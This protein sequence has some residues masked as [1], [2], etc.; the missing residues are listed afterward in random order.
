[1]NRRHSTVLGLA[2]AGVLALSA[3]G[4]GDPLDE[5]GGEEATGGGGGEEALVIGSANFPENV[6][7][8]EI[9]AA[10]LGDAGVPVETNLNIGNREA[11]MLGLEDG[12]IDLIPEYTGNLT[13]YLNEAAEETESEA[14]YAELQESLPDNLT[15]LDM[16]EAEDKDSVVVTR[17]TAD[18]LGL[19]AIGDLAPHAPNLVLGGPSEWRDRYTGVPGLKEVYGLEFSSFRPLD[20]GST[21]TVEALLNGQIDAANIFTTDPAI[22]QND[23]VVL[24]DPE[25]LFA[26]QNVVPLISTEKVT[27]QIEEVLNNVSANLTT[28]NL[29]DMMVQV[30]DTDPAEVAREFV[31]AL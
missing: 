25:A 3:C 20:A 9:Y 26:A 16:A 14:V 22:A 17:E 31:D 7:L 12:S 28:E 5:E 19:V 18:E 2:L 23:F 13:L 29:T 21:L 27:P 24:E 8:A 1:M 4:G 15:V 11:Y 6:L 30:Q 10:A